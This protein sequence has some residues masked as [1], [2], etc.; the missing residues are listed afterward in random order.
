[1]AS[2]GNGGGA[3]GDLVQRPE[4][5]AAAMRDA[6]PSPGRSL[7]TV[8][9]I[10]IAFA[11]SAALFVALDMAA[12]VP[13]HLRGLFAAPV[14][15][16]A[17]VWRARHHRSDRLVLNAPIRSG[18][19]LKGPAARTPTRARPMLPAAFGVRRPAQ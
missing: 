16:A 8:V 4:E 11:V 17:S 12:G 19:S 3:T 2:H 15:P 7:A 6:S 13:I 18:R 14:P 10:L 9:V 1:M 5:R